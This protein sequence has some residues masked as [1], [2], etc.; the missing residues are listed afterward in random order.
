MTSKVST[1]SKPK[2]VTSVGWIS[3]Y[4]WMTVLAL[5]TSIVIN[6][7]WGNMI[8]DVMD[9]AI[10]DFNHNPMRELVGEF[11]HLEEGITRMQA[12]IAALSLPTE[13]LDSAV[14]ETPLD[15]RMYTM[16]QFME[17]FRV[18]PLDQP[19]VEDTDLEQALEAY[20]YKTDPEYLRAPD[21]YNR[22]SSLYSPYIDR[23]SSIDNR[24]YIKWNTATQRY[25][26][27][28]RI[29]LPVHAPLGIFTGVI[30]DQGYDSSDAWKYRGTLYDEAGEKRKLV[31]DGRHKSNW[32][33]FLGVH[34]KGNTKV[35]TFP[36]DKRWYIF[37][38]TDRP[39]EAH[40]ELHLAAS[41]VS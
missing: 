38:E 34:G 4:T 37:F 7:F 22:L 8:L 13:D 25:A 11:D 20:D 32:F 10:Q 12:E 31:I 29:A 39:V 18:Q 6:R 3:S 35:Q 30:R 28:A 5:V 9:E 15:E 17:Y 16:K 24:F 33:Y 2:Q 14:S 27:Y 1:D 26:L 40:E 21:H 41:G 23:P 36:S 19:I